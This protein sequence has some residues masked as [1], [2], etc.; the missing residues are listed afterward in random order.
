MIGHKP[1]ILIIKLLKRAHSDLWGPHNSIF[2]EGNYYFI[3]IID[4]NTKNV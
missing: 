4:N 3:I 1:M 2:I